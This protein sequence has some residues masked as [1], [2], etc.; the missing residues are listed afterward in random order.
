MTEDQ[1]TGPGG[2]SAA[3]ESEFEPTLAEGGQKAVD[4]LVE[5]TK[6]DPSAPFNLVSDL[7]ELKQAKRGTFET[8][9]LRLK[10]A[11]CRVGELDKLINEETGEVRERD[12]SA[13]D[14]LIE[15]AD[16]ADLFHAPDDTAYTDVGVNGHRETWSIRSKGFKR[17]LL[18]AYYR[19]TS[20]APNSEALAS[21]LSVLE[22]KA[23]HDGPERP[24]FLRVGE[25]GGKIY[26]DLCDAK[27]RAVEIDETGWRIVYRPEARFRR[28]PDMK[29]LPEPEPNGSAEG[30]RRLLN[31][32]HDD[33]DFIMAKAYL[34]ATLRP[35]GP[36]PVNVVGGDQGTAKST[37]SALLSSVVDPR[38]PA[39]RSLPRDERDLFI[40]ARN[41]HVLGFDNVSGI[42]VW[43]SDALCPSLPAPD[44][45]R[46][47]FTPMMT[48]FCST[49][50]G[51][52]S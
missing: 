19:E 18:R 48:K 15:L 37:R 22:A 21:S 36:Y 46:G 40:A 14:I 27:W 38:R 23:V 41:R 47:S 43:L 8:L 13:A 31:I 2:F 35:R 32:G 16:E 12:P 7:A 10:Q 6:S 26:L 30:L 51:R 42:S 29:A 4:E 50:R 49:G 5:K 9:R 39:L 3:P 34:L 24:V 11:G 25:A 28:S 20:G 52:S 33:A 44:L 17:W 45:A 1:A